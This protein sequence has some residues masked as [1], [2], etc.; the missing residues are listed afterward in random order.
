MNNFVQD[1][2]DLVRQSDWHI[3]QLCETSTPGTIKVSQ[4]GCQ[5]SICSLT[6]ERVMIAQIQSHTKILSAYALVARGYKF[7]CCRV[8]R[9]DCHV[10]R[11]LFQID[12]RRSQYCLGTC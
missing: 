9:P 7:V 12:W 8:Q 11:H 5:Y 2:Q 6:Y 10:L 3:V 4:A 1:H